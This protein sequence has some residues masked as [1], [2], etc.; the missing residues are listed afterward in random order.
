MK[1]NPHYFD[2]SNGVKISK[3]EIKKWH[4]RVLD[5]LRKGDETSCTIVCGNSC[6]T[7]HVNELGDIVIRE[8][9]S[10]YVEY[11]YPND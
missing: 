7:G 10:G 9:T 8:F 3:A 2:F 11:T 6:V 4:D 5:V 1:Q